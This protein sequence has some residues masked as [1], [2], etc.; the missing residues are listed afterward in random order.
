MSRTPAYKRFFAELK[1]RQVFRVMA[2]YG[3]AAFAVIEAADVMFPRMG[4]PDWTVTLFVWVCLLGFPLAVVLA[5]AYERTPQGIERTDDAKPEEIEAIVA[6]PA[7]MRWPAGLLALAGCALLL[8]G[9]AGWFT[10]RRSSGA[11]RQDAT[12]SVVETAHEDSA[13]PRTKVA[14]LPFTTVGADEDD[15]RLALGVH[16][17]IITRLIRVPALAV[18][19]RNSVLVFRDSAIATGE[20][21]RTLGVGSVL[22]GSVNR[23]GDRLR[24][25]V[26]LVDVASDESVWSETFDSTWSVDALLDVQ[27]EIAEEV[28]VA[29]ATTLTETERASLAEAPTRVPEAYDAYLR[30]K[31]Y[32]DLGAGEGEFRLALQYLQQAVELDPGFALAWAA[33]SRAQ[34]YMFWQAYDRS[35]A[36]RDESRS[37]V[38]RALALDPGL[39][40]AHEA[41]GV[42]YYHGFL[43]YD[44]ALHSF[45][46]AESL[47]G[48]YASLNGAFG[49][50]YRRQGRMEEALAAFLR[51]HELDPL[52][53]TPVSE[54]GHTL[55]L[56]RRLDESVEWADR[57]IQ[58]VPESE[59]GYEIKSRAQ[60][61]GAGGAE[62]SQ[63]TLDDAD[64]LAVDAE[65]LALLRVFTRLQLRDWDGAIREAERTRH[66]GLGDSQF[67]FYPPALLSGLAHLRKGDR[68]SAGSDYMEA[69]ALLERLTAAAP[70]DERYR[71]VLGLAYAG[72]GR[73]EDALREA[74]R[75]V[76]LMPVEREAWRGAIRLGELAA[77]HAWVGNTDSAVAHLDALLSRPGEITIH[78][79]RNDPTWDPLRGEPAFERLV[80]RYESGLN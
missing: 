74:R 3:A 60:L 20:I 17:D 51:E 57:Y 38:D 34:I 28:A 66:E 13:P 39:P 76:E 29:L 23:A 15:E 53:P 35:E 71:G 59:S 21:A 22:T 62:A 7:G 41:L 30:G 37:S 19:N 8:A 56:L 24:I 61:S 6:E 4:L 25:N 31:E 11:D 12:G 49:A 47:G 63:R 33:L 73:P 52:T 65:D 2:I 75:G 9:A 69:A 79:L 67:E 26:Q 70:D 32:F 1:R 10:G 5:W 64:R 27:A 55:R 14:V 16:D 42:W 44:R 43:D 58:M 48:R 68:E 54:V 45:A 77:V 40:Q 78:Q 18:I 46:V 36:V 50:V 80:A 72:L